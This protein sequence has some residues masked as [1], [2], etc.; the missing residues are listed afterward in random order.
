MIYFLVFLLFI[1]LLIEYSING[2]NILSCGLISVCMYIIS[3]MTIVIYMDYFQYDITFKTVWVIIL[4]LILL[5]IGEAIFLKY[6]KKKEVSLEL[7]QNKE[8]PIRISYVSLTI[9]I[10]FSIIV[11]YFCFKNLF[12]A[13]SNTG[14]YGNIFAQFESARSFLVYAGEEYSKGI[15]LSQS[16]VIA[17]CLSLFCLFAYFY[18]KIYHNVKCTSYLIPIVLYILQLLSSTG[19]TGYIGLITVACIIIFVFQKDKTKWSRENDK[20]IIKYGIEA[21]LIFF[22]IFRISGYITGTSHLSSMSENIAKYV[23]SSIIGLDIFLNSSYTLNSIESSE[24]L[25]NLLLF[26]KKFGFNISYYSSHLEKFSYGNGISNVYTGLRSSIKDYTLF[27][28]FIS[29]FMLGN[30][31]GILLRKLRDNKQDM[32][33]RAVG[34]IFVGLLFYP[35]VMT[36]IAD[37]YKTI[38]SST[39]LYQMVYLYFINWFFIKRKST[40][41][42]QALR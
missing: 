35:I 32:R 21:I 42:K 38:L 1:L 14:V 3:T 16:C 8:K 2:K 22:I 18:N 17:E 5:C 12:S 31:Y 19:R 39:F 34:I 10:I 40:R 37:T 27:G 25:R 29:R 26:L 36:A 6:S 9:I 30:F 11:D 13:L 28:M 24:T 33:E 23:G 4:S 20:K 7:K 15:L 41:R